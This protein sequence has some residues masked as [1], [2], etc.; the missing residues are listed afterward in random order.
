MVETGD[1][2]PQPGHSAGNLP[3][4]N[5]MNELLKFRLQC[6]N[7]DTYISYAQTELQ[8]SSIHHTGLNW[9]QKNGNGLLHSF[10]SYLGTMRSNVLPCLM[11]KHYDS[12]L[13]FAR[14]T[15]PDSNTEFPKKEFIIFDHSGNQTSVMYSSGPAQIPISISAKNCSHGLNDDDEEEAAGDIDLK[16]YLFHKGPLKNGIAGE[17]SEMHED[18]EEINALLYSD[19]DNHYSSDDEVTST[20]HSPSLIKELYDKQI[21]EMNEE[22]ASSDGP[23]KRQRMLDCGHKKL[24]DAPVSVKVDAFNNYRVDMKSSYTGGDS[25]GHLMNSSLG[26]FSSKKDKLRETLKLLETMVPGAEGKHPMLVIDEAIDYLK[27]L[28]FKAKAMGLAAST[29][30]RRD[31]GQEC[32]DG[33]K[34]C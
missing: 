11:E 34:K 25:Q 13:G 22:V 27:S 26:K 15:L 17:E 28:K 1:S 6:L 14:M 24:S 29:L 2:W 18:T 16:N 21:E 20:G 3:N 33:R 31:V 7:P 32:Q 30:P 5:C 8:G 12:S 23:R 9:E 10:P 4:L 19:D